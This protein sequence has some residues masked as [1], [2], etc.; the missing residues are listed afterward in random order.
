MTKRVI[1]IR[2]GSAIGFSLVSLVYASLKNGDLMINYL[3]T[4]FMFG[5]FFLMISGIFFVTMG[6]FFKVFGMGW[7]RLFTRNDPYNDDSHW[8][9]DEEDDDKENLELRKKTKRELFIN[10]PFFIGSFLVI[11]ALIITFTVAE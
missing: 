7:K 10:L 9:N 11:Q 6:G 1:T 5:I 2:I 8:S 3:N 4:S